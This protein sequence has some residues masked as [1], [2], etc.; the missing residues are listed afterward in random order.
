MNLKF[1]FFI[2]FLPLFFLS[3]FCAKEIKSSSLEKKIADASTTDTAVLTLCGLDIGIDRSTNYMKAV[4]NGF[5]VSAGHYQ[6]Q[7]NYP[8]MLDPSAGDNPKGSIYIGATK[9][10]QLIRTTPGPKIVFGYSQGA[11][12]AGTWL[13]RFAHLPDA[14]PSNE[15]SF[16]LIGNPERRYGKQP[17]TL[18]QTPDSTQYKIRD[19]SR[20]NDNWSDWHGSPS[21]NRILAMFGTVHTNYWKS[22]IYGE[23]AQVIKVVGN[24][25][26][27]IVP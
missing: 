10:D 7:V 22:E 6:K 18:K 5:A 27:V 3:F 19:V 9:L 25:S 8:A 26:Y 17:W 1:I 4:C 12:V 14:P 16:V 11:Q 15:L 21:D 24:T 2:T 23:S 13:R 20:K